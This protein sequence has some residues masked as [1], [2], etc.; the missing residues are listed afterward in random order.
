MGRLS[1]W[2]D[3]AERADSRLLMAIVLMIAIMATQ[4]ISSL[5]FGFAFGAFAGTSTMPLVLAFAALTSYAVVL[6]LVWRNLRGDEGISLAD[7]GLRAGRFSWPLT[8]GLAVIIYLTCSMIVGVYVQVTGYVNEQQVAAWVSESQG[9]N[10]IVVG[11]LVLAIVV[12]GPAVEELVFRGYLQTALA[13]K[14]P[15]WAAVGISSLVFGAFHMELGAF[16]L[17]VMVG[18]A[19]GAVYQITGTLWPAILMHMVS[20]GLAIIQIFNGE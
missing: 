7:I 16:P 6:S 8:L 9:M 5:L 19:F 4:L 20:N 1:D 14:I 17:L 10:P 2:R 3:S 15:P 13:E 12:I 11:L 18:A